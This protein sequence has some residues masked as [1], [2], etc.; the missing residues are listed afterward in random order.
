MEALAV[1]LCIFL[2]LGIPVALV[3]MGLVVSS[4]SARTSHQLIQLR[5][6]VAQLRQRLDTTT[7]RRGREPGV[8]LVDLP[9]S[10]PPATPPTT[11]TED[12]RGDEADTDPSAA[13]AVAAAEGILD[14][15]MGAAAPS[16]REL[17]PHTP[18]VASTREGNGETRALPPSRTA[19]GPHR[20]ARARWRPPAP[21]RL[22]VWLGAG[23]GGFLVVLA[24]LFA[25][26]VVIDRGW[27]GPGIRVGLGLAAGTGLWW[28]AML[29]RDRGYT[30]LVSATSG[31]GVGVLYGMLFAAHGLYGLLDQ[32]TCF[33]LM[34]AVTAVSIGSAIRMQDRLMA[35][36]GLLG[37]VLTPVL[38]S[39]GTNNAAGL[40]SY[41]ALLIAGAVL[42]AARKGWW[43]VVLSAF[44]SVIV[45][46]VGWSLSWRAPDQLPVALLALGA[47]I[48]PFV[49]GAWSRQGPRAVRTV[50][51]AAVFALPLLALGWLIPIDPLFVDPHTFLEVWRPVGQAPLWVAGALVLLPA[52]AWALAR[53]LDHVVPV[54]AATV[55]TSALMAA[56]SLGWSTTPTPPLLLLG[57]APL[58]ALALG[59]LG[60]RP[61]HASTW[62]LVPLPALTG[63]V[64]T[65]TLNTDSITGVWLLGAGAGL[66]G[67]GLILARTTRRGWLLLTTLAGVTI[68]LMAGAARVEDLGANWVA[69]PTVLAYALLATLPL[70]TTWHHDG[71]GPAITAAISGPALFLPL[72]LCWRS[73]LGDGLIGA[74]PVLLGASA[75]VGAGVL[76]RVHGVGRSSGTLAVFVAVVLLGL[77]AAVPLQLR[78]QWLTVAWA[79]EAAVLARAARHLTHPL[80]RWSSVVLATVVTVR[81]VLNPW[82]LEYGDASGLP[83]LN[84]TLWTWGVPAAAVLATARWLDPAPGA[85]TAPTV[86]KPIPAALRL[87]A[88]C[89]GFALVNVQVS[90]AFQDAGPVDLGGTGLLQGMVRSITW[91]LYGVALLVLGLWRQSQATRLVGFAVVLLA[92]AKVFAVDLW[93]LSGFARVGSVLGLGVTLLAAAFLFERL[94]L[95]RQ[96]ASDSPK[97]RPDGDDP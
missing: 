26:S 47:L 43:D 64:L 76:V 28:G 89:I 94:V 40:F 48:L 52:P 17:S 12:P 22:A 57:A 53:R 65:L 36:L 14:A 75:L 91:G 44:V 10:L 11:T 67:V 51:A 1:I 88:V 41:L 7:G 9:K 32:L 3:V 18:P 6:E 13:P 95:R 42:P 37:G 59:A 68:L 34:C 71:R 56:F 8:G 62:G 82:A 31:A 25:V 61:G 70:L 90:H 27:M 58:A 87:M 19:K 54:A 79:L 39:T 72:Y 45:I 86:P 15:P 80:L 49:H 63:A 5:E 29:L 20:A 60:T 21:E 30:R 2:L 73:G 69:A 78:D 38:L 96:E 85:Q 35:H 16:P 83:I 77:T 84:W 23:L 97:L 81:L 92:T 74:L 66:A 33:G 50:A 93:S 4:R 24:S 46:F 55:V